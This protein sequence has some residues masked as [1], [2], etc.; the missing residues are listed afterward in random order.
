MISPINNSQHPTPA[1]EAK[2]QP[3]KPEPQTQAPKNGA[4][5]HDHVTL[6]NSGQ[7]NREEQSE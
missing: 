4:L 5:S 3:R 6:K 2:Q 1:S 7:A